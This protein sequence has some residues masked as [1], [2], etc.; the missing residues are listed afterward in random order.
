MADALENL[1]ENCGARFLSI[2]IRILNQVVLNVRAAKLTK[3]QHVMFLLADMM[4]WCEVGKALCEKAVDYDGTER[5]PEYLKAAA[6]LFTR[7]VSEKVYVNGLKIACG[8]DKDMSEVME[9]LNTLNLG[10]VMRDR[11]RDMD[12]V[13]E[14]LLK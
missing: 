1:P 2:A 9:S 11:L 7:D 12:L 13:V 6:R 3:S 5:T 8:C 4:A 10:E 14:E